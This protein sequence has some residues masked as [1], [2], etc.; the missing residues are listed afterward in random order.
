MLAL[1]KDSSMQLMMRVMRSP[2][3]TD[4]KPGLIRDLLCAVDQT[5][6]ETQCQDS[7]AINKSQNARGPAEPE[8]CS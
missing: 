4:R 8:F 5:A 6:S 7:K 3:E 1:Q 2:K